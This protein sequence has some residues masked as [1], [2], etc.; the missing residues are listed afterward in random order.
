MR[1][2]SGAYRNFVIEDSEM[3]GTIGVWMD[4]LQD[5][6]FQIALERTRDLCRTKIEFAPTPAEIY[7]ACLESHSFYELQR[8]EEQQELLEL[9]Q[10]NEQAVP[11]PDH[12]RERLERRVKR[13][14]NNNE[15]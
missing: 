2:I 6:P 7:Q 11:M 14:V 15:S 3:E 12:I 1:Y 10:Y 9:Q 8:I 5:I 4:I 13:T